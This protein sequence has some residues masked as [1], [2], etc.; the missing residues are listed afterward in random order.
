[1]FASSE[2]V[3][4]VACVGDSITEGSGADEG[5]SY[6]A[7]LQQLLGAGWLVGNFGRSGCSLLKKGDFPYWNESV[8]RSALNFRP[9]VV[10]IML[11]TNDTKP[12]NWRYREEF[13]GDYL[14]LVES[15]RGLA[16]RPRIHVCLPCPVFGEGN[17][18][19]TA[20]G[21][22]EYL[23]LIQDLATRRSLGLIDLHS[24]LCDK[25]QLI[26]DRV[27]PSTE[28]AAELAKAVFAKLRI[29]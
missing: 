9:D 29:D 5:M 21:L 20:E 22:A 24:I 2:K 18:D 8:C 23:K 6:P 16:T 3:I 11:G 10:V 12:Q 17:F 4:R 28:G 19:I 15:F 14:E 26:P 1:M 7:Q 25:P 13:V 27:H